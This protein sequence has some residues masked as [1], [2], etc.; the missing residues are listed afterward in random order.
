MFKDSPKVHPRL[1]V[2]SNCEGNDSCIQSEEGPRKL[3]FI[4]HI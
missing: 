3:Q 4:F 1:N 2:T